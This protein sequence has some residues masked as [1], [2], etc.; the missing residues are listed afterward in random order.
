[1]RLKQGMYLFGTALALL[2]GCG[3]AT[4][5]N[6][7]T[8]QANSVNSPTSSASS[9]AQV[10]S[11][12][13]TLQS[14]TQ[15]ILAADDP[16]LATF[17]AKTIDLPSVTTI[18]KGASGIQESHLLRLND[19]AQ[20]VYEVGQ[21]EDLPVAIFLHGGPGFSYTNSADNMAGLVGDANILFWDQIGAGHTFSENPTLEPSMDNLITSLE[22]LVT[23]AK[24]RY[25]VDKV[26]I[27]GHSWGSALGATYARTH[28][29]DVSVYIGV[30]QVVTSAEDE[31]VALAETKTRA[32]A[33][34]RSDLVDQLSEIDAA[35]PNQENF[36]EVAYDAALLRSVQTELGYNAAD[37]VQYLPLLFSGQATNLS[38][39][40]QAT[41]DRLLLNQRLYRQLLKSDFYA[42]GTSFEMPFYLISGANDIQVPA[43]QARQL[44][45]DIDAPDKA[46]Y[47]IPDAGHT[48]MDDQ[49]TQFNQ[50]I[51]TILKNNL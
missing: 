29:D 7:K 11:T 41:L 45:E 2:A 48:P 33:A 34:G 38:A 47:E 50:L 35:Y 6:Q 36:I 8:E 32:E 46:Y 12:T 27:I 5:A 22:D 21:G 9:T 18:D 51:R 10:A 40:D 49:A 31:Q 16:A 37:F 44:I 20:Y 30:G 4:T 42:E 1:M 28:P 14:Q 25:G 15:T 13:T 43:S 17:Q 19:V 39:S 26:A 3:Q 24:T 23:Y